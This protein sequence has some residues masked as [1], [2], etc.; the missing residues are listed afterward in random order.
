MAEDS[1]MS[2]LERQG[3]RCLERNFRSKTGE[4][5]LVMEDRGTLVFVEVR[6]R[7]NQRYGSALDSI[8]HGKQRRLLLT[9]QCY[10]Q[11]RRARGRTRFDVVAVEPDSDQSLKFTWVKDAIQDA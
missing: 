10:L 6:Y 9:A 8:D 11:A 5:D 4:I 3:L 7:R 2:F 1:A